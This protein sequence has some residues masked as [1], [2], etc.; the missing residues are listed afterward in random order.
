MPRKSNGAAHQLA[1]WPGEPAITRAD[2]AAYILARTP[3]TPSTRGSAVSGYYAGWK[4][5]ERI[6]RIKHL[7]P[8]EWH[9]IEQIAAEKA[10]KIAGPHCSPAMF[11]D[12][13]AAAWAYLFEPS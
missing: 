4:V 9:E 2:V 7:A 1:L 8:Q 12:H 10:E 11:V 5:V 3:Y 13:L 6:R